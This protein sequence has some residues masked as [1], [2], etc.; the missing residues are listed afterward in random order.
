MEEAEKYFEQGNEAYKEDNLEQAI[1]HYTQAIHLKP[2]DA[3]AYYNR[4][5]C[6]E[7]MGDYKAAL[8]DYEQAILLKPDYAAAYNNRGSCHNEMGN[9][10]AALKDYD[11][12]IKLKP[13]YANAYYNR[14]NCHYEMGNHK[15]ALKDYDQAILLK[16]DFAEAYNNRGLCHDKMGDYKAALKDYDKAIKLKPDYANAYNNRGLCHEK[17]GKHKAALKDYDQAILLKSDYAD[18]YYNRGNCHYE[19]GKHKAAL[20]D[21]DQAIL[22][23]SD[24]ADAYYNR[25]ICHYKMGNY[26]AALKDYDQ[27]ILLKPDYAKAYNNRGGCHYEMGKHKAALKDYDQAILLKPD[28]ANA[29]YNRGAC[30]GNMGNSFEACKNFLKSNQLGLR[31]SGAVLMLLHSTALSPAPYLIKRLAF[32]QLNPSYYNQYARVIIDS[33]KLCN[34]LDAYL[35]LAEMQ[36]MQGN[37]PKAEFI[38]LLAFTNY[39][40]GDPITAHSLFK[41]YL[42]ECDG[43]DLQAYH[44]LALSAEEFLMPYEE[45]KRN[46][47]AL[48]ESY[49][50]N[51]EQTTEPKSGGFFKRIGSFLTGNKAKEETITEREIHQSYYAGHIFIKNKENEKAL[52]CFQKVQAHF[53]PAAYMCF[54]LLDTSRKNEAA[55]KVGFDIYKREKQ[56]EKGNGIGYAKGVKQYG[57][58]FVD[59]EY[60]LETI[61]PAVHFS[62]ISGAIKPFRAHA[63]SEFPSLEVCHANTQPAFYDLF[64]FKAEDFERANHRVR[65]F[66][67]ETIGKS[68]AAFWE[69]DAKAL[70]SQMDL[71]GMEQ[72]LNIK[73]KQAVQQ[74]FGKLEQLHKPDE[75]ELY[76]AARMEQKEL[77]FDAINLLTAYAFF[78]D[79]IDTETYVMLRIYSLFAYG[80]KPQN[81]GVLEAFLSESLKTVFGELAPKVAKH[82]V[83]TAVSVM[84]SPFLVSTPLQALLLATTSGTAAVFAEVVVPHI[85]QLAQNNPQGLSYAEFKQAFYIHIGEVR[86]QMGEDVFFK[87]YHVEGF[88]EWAKGD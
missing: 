37:F 30:Y 77:P 87:R 88:E 43:E 6:H 34:H 64:R 62:E 67:L 2:D 58:L 44:Y 42:L 56:A 81:M 49:L 79:K 4:G 57:Q 50:P 85:M 23:K 82:A 38:K 28:F 35:A 68:I 15:A 63:Q 65:D 66:R 10:K 71:D 75:V 14:G 78:A 16:P 11:Q 32:E 39:F 5:V 60:F 29:Y 1:E 52:R 69:M 83:P 41:Q 26:D 45:E 55:K 27:A 18:A 20:K 17:M 84:L 70:K 31:Q 53:L 13:D 22:L 47:L 24:Y 8:K 59:E 36:Y 3:E 12:A 33:L 51:V 40:M 72:H 74:A 9:Y 54:H 73:A 7:K 46:A 48:A 80:K 21:Y 61:M 86:E 19:M 25:G 76:L